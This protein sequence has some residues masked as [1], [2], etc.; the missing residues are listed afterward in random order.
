MYLH[1]GAS[2]K[3]RALARRA[4]LL[5][6][7]ALASKHSRRHASSPGGLSSQAS[8]QNPPQ[9]LT[10]ILSRAPQTPQE[11]P[12]DCF[13]AYTYRDERGCRCCDHKICQNRP[14]NHKQRQISCEL[15]QQARPPSSPGI[16]RPQSVCRPALG[17]PRP[18]ERR[19]LTGQARRCLRRAP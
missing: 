10:S 16:A 15:T 4:A 19:A 8:S 9:R 18:A 5:P 14:I 6:F 1:S 13:C 11:T 3:S 17:S 2:S 12:V 7:S